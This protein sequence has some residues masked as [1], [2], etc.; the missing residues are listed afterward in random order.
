MI[1]ELSLK[2][3]SCWRLHIEFRRFHTGG[4]EGEPRVTTSEMVRA[5]YRILAP[6]AELVKTYVAGQFSDRDREYK[7]LECERCEPIQAII[8]VVCLPPL[9]ELEGLETVYPSPP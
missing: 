1:H 2:G 7:L 5:Y 4:M 3:L 8:N 6:D 9:Q